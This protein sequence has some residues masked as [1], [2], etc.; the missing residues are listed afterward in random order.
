[1]NLAASLAIPVIVITFIGVAAGEYPGLKMNRA[2]ITLVG[3]VLLVALGVI[4]P[5]VALNSIDPATLLLLFAM[6]IINTHLRLAGLFGWFVQFIVQHALSPRLLLAWIVFTSGILAAL[7]LNDTVVLMF[8][9]LVLD[10]TL[11]LRRNPLPYLIGLAAAANIGSAATITGNPQNMFIGLASHISFVTFLSTLGPVALL[12]LTIAWLVL[13]VV[14]R[15]E[16]EQPWPTQAMILQEQVD[17]FLLRKSLA[18]VA[19]M[20]VAFFAGVSVPLA[21]MSVAAALLIS[22]RIQPETIFAQIDW[23]LLVFFGSLF[24]VTGAL[25]YRHIIDPFFTLVEPLTQGGIAPLTVTTAILS[26]L[27]SNVPAVLLFRSTVPQLSDPNRV[28]LT[29]AMASTLAGNLTLLGSV[30]NLIVA[31]IAHRRGVKI[32][33][34]DYLKAGVPI[35]ILTLLVGIVWLS[36]V[37]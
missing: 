22:R 27:V 23:P 32:S 21:T 9:P 34:R 8:T 26:N 24:V 17:R 31:E 13:I 2:T 33:F 36:A 25:E 37:R 35:T 20:L 7:F 15:N 29:L 18:L 4:P 6:M 19:L 5:S 12:G 14:Y 11:A 1:M 28:W 3:A 16:F 30:A 10:V